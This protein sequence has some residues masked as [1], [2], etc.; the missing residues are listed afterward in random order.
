VFSFG[1]VFYEIL[2]GQPVFSLS[3]GPFEILRQIKGG[4]MPDIPTRVLPGIKSLIEWYWSLN[5]TQRP[6]F[7]A[8]LHEIQ[9]LNFEIIPG[10][11]ANE[12]IAYIRGVRDWEEM[13]RAKLSNSA[14]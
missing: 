14:S 2:V 8:I 6:S 12:V 5:P 11:D 10:S 4:Q 9:S 7:N 13:N 1:L 3:Q